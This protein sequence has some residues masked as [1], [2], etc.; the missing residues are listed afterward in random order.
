MTMAM[1]N[2]QR[3]VVYV[4]S[5]ASAGR[6][7]MWREKRVGGW[8]TSSSWVDEGSVNGGK[9]SPDL[10]FRI[11]CEIGESDGLIL[12]AEPSDFPLKGALVEVGIALAYRK[13]VILVLPGVVIDSRY[14][15]LGSWITLPG[16]IQC[17]TLDVAYAEVGRAIARG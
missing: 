5:R 3:P 16:V 8:L 9:I 13:P 2:N 7:A 4:A 11:R 17:P 6:V 15:P 14:R 1:K 10:W 12:Y